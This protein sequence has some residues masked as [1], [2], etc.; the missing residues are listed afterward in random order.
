MDRSHVKGVPQREGDLVVFAEIG[1]PVPGE[2]A[3]AADDETRAIRCDSVAKRLGV[4]RQIGFED[5]VASV[6]EDVGTHAS[7]VEIDAGVECVGMVVEAHG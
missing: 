7:C 4:G 3:L 6:I 1:E 5:G 2:H